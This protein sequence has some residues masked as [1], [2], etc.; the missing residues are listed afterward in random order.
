MPRERPPLRDLDAV[1]VGLAEGEQDADGDRQS[2]HEGHE[3][4]GGAQLLR[5]HA[6]V[7]VDVGD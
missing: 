6:C 4:L 3:Q 1:Q 5:D 7:F 2:A